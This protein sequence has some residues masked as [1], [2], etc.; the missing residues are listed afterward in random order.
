[1]ERSAPWI[2]ILWLVIFPSIVITSIILHLDGGH[3]TY[4]LDDP[5]IHLALAKN[6]ML[7]NYGI[8]PGELEAPSSSILWPFLLAP[9]SLLP[10]IAFELTPL[11]LNLVCLSVFVF[12]LNLLFAALPMRQR[13]FTM[14]CVV[15]SLNAI[16]LV[17]N[18]MEHELQV[19][20][21][22]LIVLGLVRKTYRYVY[23][24]AIL[25]PFVRY[26]GLAIS[27][28]ALV[29]C[30]YTVNRRYSLLALIVIAI[31]MCSFSLWL[32][33]HGLGYLPS[34]VLAKSRMTDGV[35]S[36]TY[37]FLKN[38]K[39]YG[40]MVP[41]ICVL[42]LYYWRIDRAMALVVISATTLHLLFGQSG[43]YGRYEV[44]WLTFVLLLAICA[45]LDWLTVE[46]FAYVVPLA[47]ALPFF[48]T[49]L[50]WD[51]ISVPLASSNIAN[52]QG[53]MADIARALGEP[54]AANDIGLISL[55]SHVYVLDVLGLGS[56]AVLR[57][58]QAGVGSAW[59]E[60]AMK[61]KGIEYAFIYDAWYPDRPRDWIKVATL[62]LL[63]HRVSVGRL[64]VSFY[65]T[66][67]AAAAKLREVMERDVARVD[68]GRARIDFSDPLPN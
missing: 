23:I 67:R 3:F 1:M 59:I 25:L 5:Y 58:R 2:P 53:R 60:S 31:G 44:Y 50:A 54:V 56:I 65:A 46:R 36:I 35:F 28:P 24:A 18:G 15:L 4:T 21:V 17:F 29:Y 68:W 40:F 42:S 39:Q 14:A 10:E 6:I 41:A 33:S 51:T 63:E 7:G 8:N 38:L 16:G 52:Q 26:E 49:E 27:L 20:L 12:I 57:A 66:N 45:V 47:A 48:F 43:W 11:V 62:N 55:R 34:S 13:L 19:V 22:A 37:N 9:F 61:S 30:F 64:I 32:H